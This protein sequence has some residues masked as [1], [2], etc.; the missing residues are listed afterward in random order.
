MTAGMP[1]TFH[2]VEAAIQAHIDSSRNHDSLAD[3]AIET[4]LTGPGRELSGKHPEYAEAFQALA[5]H[6]GNC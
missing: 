3:A 5:E 2:Q 1:D 6:L 4:I